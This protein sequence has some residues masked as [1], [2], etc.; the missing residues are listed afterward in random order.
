[1]SLKTFENILFQNEIIG[2]FADVQS[3]LLVLTLAFCLGH[4][5]SWVYMM[6]HTGLSY[7]QSYTAALIMMTVLVSLVMLLMS[8]NIFVA[9]GLMAVFGFVRFR[10]SM[11]DTRDTAFV[12]WAI[13][14]GM[15][16]GTQK[17]G[18][19]ITACFTLAVM[20]LYLR[21]TSLGAKQRYDVVLSL[22]LSSD[23]GSMRLL[24]PILKR[25]STHIQLASQRS[26]TEDL[27][28]LSYRLLLRNPRRSGELLEE[29]EATQGVAHVSLYQREDESEL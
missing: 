13:I 15:A 9:F 7:S 28:D 11:K 4:V 23:S 5:I 1:M 29:L 19:A 14:Q 21:L 16:V 6:T 12:L 22:H 8:G 17:Y 27:L 20:V 26:L 10:N 18:I 25:H 3:V 24:Q 2:G